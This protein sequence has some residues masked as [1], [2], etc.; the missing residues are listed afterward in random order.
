MKRYASQSRNNVLRSTLISPLILR[1]Q[2]Q[3]SLNS[4]TT[5]SRPTLHA[6]GNSTERK[7]NPSIEKRYS[8]RQNP[9]SR[10]TSREAHHKSETITCP[11]LAQPTRKSSAHNV[12]SI[13]RSTSLNHLKVRRREKNLFC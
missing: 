13:S 4:R 10:L 1:K 6:Q 2:R 11:T 9:Q 8:D 3:T 7:S 5:F 12:L